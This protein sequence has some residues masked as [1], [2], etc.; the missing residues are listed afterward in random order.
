MG[1]FYTRKKMRIPNY[2]YAQGN[3]VFLTICVEGRKNVLGRIVKAETESELPRVELSEIGITVER[4]TSTIAGIEKYVIMPNHVHMIV[5]NEEGENISQKMHAWKSLITRRIGK[6]IW[7]R[8]FY[9]HVIRDERDYNVKCKYIEDNPSKWA[10]DEYF[11][12]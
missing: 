4:Y 10:L 11:Q 2:D 1:Q 8:T 7:Q 9:D 6:S 12:K 5:I 3:T